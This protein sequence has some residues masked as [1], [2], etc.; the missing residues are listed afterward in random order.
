MATTLQG[1][2][3]AA[4]PGN[5]TDREWTSRRTM[6]HGT[7]GPGN[8]L[9]NGLGNGLGNALSHSVSESA[10]ETSPLSTRPILL[11]L[12]FAVS[13]AGLAFGLPVIIIGLAIL[14][15]RVGGWAG[16]DYRGKFR[17]PA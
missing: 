14:A 7:G 10:H 2:A 9:G 3:A 13:M 1:T 11:C 8:V 6:P 4:K 5:S 12:G 15:W 17:L 16:D